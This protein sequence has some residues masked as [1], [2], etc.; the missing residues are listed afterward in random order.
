MGID[1]AKRALLK[2]STGSLL[3]EKRSLVYAVVFGIWAEVYLYCVL[4]DLYLV[5]ISA[6]HF[7]KYHPPLWGLE[8]ATA[9]AMG[10]AFRASVGPGL[11]LGLAAVF[12]GRAGSRPKM[13]LGK[14]LKMVAILIVITELIGLATGA[15]A[16]I[17]GK[18]LYPQIVYPELTRPLVTTQTIQLTCYLVGALSGLGF[19]IWVVKWRARQ[20]KA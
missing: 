2:I 18:T 7:T 8:N 14:M 6:E 12:L 11:V 13:P 19:L 16:W 5:R 1:G 20:D 9:V 17:T 10:W 3:D 15:Y 4:H